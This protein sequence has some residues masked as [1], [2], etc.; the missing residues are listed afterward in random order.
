MPYKLIYNVYSTY[1]Y[2]ILYLVF[3]KTGP[4]VPTN[5]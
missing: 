3:T 1:T 2:D 4:D 5:I